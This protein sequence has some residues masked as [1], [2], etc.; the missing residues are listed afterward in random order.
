MSNQQFNKARAFFNGQPLGDVEDVRVEQ[1]ANA[2]RVLRLSAYVCCAVGKHSGIYRLE[3]DQQVRVPLPEIR[4]MLEGEQAKA[5]AANYGATTESI[6]EAAR[7]A[8]ITWEQACAAAEHVGN[9]ALMLDVKDTIGSD[10]QLTQCISWNVVQLEPNEPPV[11]NL[12]MRAAPV[13]DLQEV[14]GVGVNVAMS[15]ADAPMKRQVLFERAYEVQLVVSQVAR[16]QLTEG[17]VAGAFDE[18][19]EAA[20]ELERDE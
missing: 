10:L 2:Q 1:Q 8:Y 20:G 12:H 4:P 15:V 5:L 14:F 13:L 18:F 16:V 11:L 9:Y 6:L 3:G 7:H 19:D 17:D